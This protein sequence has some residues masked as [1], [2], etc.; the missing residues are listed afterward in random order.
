[1]HDYKRNGTTT[2][3]AALDV[4]TKEIL[5]KCLPRH[6]T[7]EFVTFLKHIDRSIDKA[8]QVHLVVDN[9]GT[10]SHPNVVAWLAKHPR[11]HLHFTPT[12]SS[13]LNLV[14]RWFRELTTKR[15]MRG[16]FASV[17]ELIAAIE[18]YLE[19]SNVDAKPCPSSGRRRPRRSSKRSNEDELPSNKRA[20]IEK[21]TT[22][23]T[24][25]NPGPQQPSL[26]Q[27]QKTVTA[28]TMKRM[29]SISDHSR[30]WSPR[31]RGYTAAAL[32]ALEM[33]LLH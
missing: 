6:R 1:M 33:A 31:R 30:R 14:E 24:N 3:F 11:Y 8:L 29:F 7:D 4:L 10:R 9:Y 13:W 16:S 17:G 22:R 20:S 25:S 19:H 21:H 5:G 27:N 12:S 18:D 23:R 26:G 15:L 28:A 32:W 2:L